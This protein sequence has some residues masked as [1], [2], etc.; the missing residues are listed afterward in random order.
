MVFPGETMLGALQRIQVN[1]DAPCGGNGT[2]GR[3]EVMVYG[4]GKVKAIQL[5]AL[6]EL[7]KRMYS[8]LVENI[9]IKSSE[10]IENLLMNELRYEKREK[11]K[12][13]LYK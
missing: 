12:L 3:C 8:P 10:D 7:T 9:T 11:I 6:C 1:I 2:C 5:K 4:I 13:I